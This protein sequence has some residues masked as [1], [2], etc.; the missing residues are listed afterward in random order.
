[1]DEDES[2]NIALGSA[3]PL[4]PP[5]HAK[6]TAHNL[7]LLGLLTSAEASSSSSF[8]SSSSPSSAKG[9]QREILK[10]EED[11]PDWDL[12]IEL[13]EPR[14]DWIEEDGQYEVFGATYFVSST[15]PSFPLSPSP[16]PPA[17]KGSPSSEL[18]IF[19]SL[20]VFLCYRSLKEYRMSKE[21]E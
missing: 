20:V 7:R 18:T 1:M 5:H 19:L 14:V 6:F 15:F 11:V 2:E 9:K 16:S 21:W 8:P 17:F 12:E 3:F 13:K 10:D 4:P